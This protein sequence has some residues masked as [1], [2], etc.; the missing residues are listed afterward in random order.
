[1]TSPNGMIDSVRELVR[2]YFETHI[3]DERDDA[4][5]RLRQAEDSATF[6]I[7]QVAADTTGA[8]RRATQA[9]RDEAVAGAERVGSAEAV[10]A[11]VAQ[12]RG[13]RVAA[14][15]AATE[16]AT[17]ATESAESAR[18]AAETALAG[19]PDGGVG[20]TKLAPE[21]VDEIDSKADLGHK[22]T[23]AEITDLP[24]VTTANSGSAIVQRGTTGHI[25]VPPAPTNSTHATSRDYVLNQVGTRATPA[26]VDQEVATR[27]TPDVVS[28]MISA[29]VD[30]LVGGA[31][32][33]LDT[34]YEIAAELQ[35]Q[36]EAVAALITQIAGK[37]KLGHEHV[38]KEITDLPEVT[39]S[40]VGGAIVQRTSTGDINVP[41]TP[42]GDLQAA[43]GGHVK[44]QVATRTTPADVSSMITNNGPQITFVAAGSAPATAPAGQLIM[45]YES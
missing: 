26:Y 4:L 32:D 34:L 45:E 2:Q 18:Q 13:D 16:S 17:S 27:T 6:T 36:D 38:M 12:V 39:L 10:T 20:R 24:E 9:A 30:A 44:D 3:L 41:R 43:S 33:A 15:D 11:A 37:A 7:N 31:P 22:H 35:D 14:Q 19:I 8:D 29:A 40:E 25:A 42:D 21:V 23:K 1:M 5:A 28:S